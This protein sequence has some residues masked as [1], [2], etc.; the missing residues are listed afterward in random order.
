MFTFLEDFLALSF[1]IQRPVYSG[2]VRYVFTESWLSVD[3]R[4]FIMEWIGQIFEAEF[5]DN[6][7]KDC[8]HLK[9]VYS[10]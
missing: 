4:S 2:A 5:T 8:Y 7:K 1:S 10:Q 6:L 9:I 3:I